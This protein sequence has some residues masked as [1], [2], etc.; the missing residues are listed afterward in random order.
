MAKGPVLCEAEL[1]A[2]VAE[3]LPERET[4]LFDVNIAPVIGVNLAMAINAASIGTS[5]TALAGQ[6]LVNWHM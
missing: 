2:Q 3:L 5:A 1:D 6:T 4:L